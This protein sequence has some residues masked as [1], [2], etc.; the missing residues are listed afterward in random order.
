MS[1]EN[2]PP[3]RTRLWALFARDAHQAVVLRRGPRRHFRL[4]TW[5]THTDRF[6]HGQWMTGD[7]T[8]Y[9]LSPD[10]TKLIYWA[11]QYG[12]AAVR[13]RQRAEAEARPAGETYDPVS[14]RSR[15]RSTAKRAYRKMPRYLRD[16]PAWPQPPASRGRPN[17]GVWT[18]ISTP[19]YFSALAIWPSFGHWT[20]GGWFAGSHEL[21]LLEGDCGM[22][23]KQNAPLPRRLKIRPATL[24]ERRQMARYGAAARP[25]YDGDE[26]GKPLASRLQAEGARWVDWT[27]PAPTGDLLFACDGRIWRLRNWQ[28]PEQTDLI[29]TATMIADFRDMTFASLPPPASAMSWGR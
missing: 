23:A 17:T 20:G 24:T 4:S 26:A 5:D 27:Y 1:P 19:P 29:A 11:Y 10:G 7:V 28:G 6:T 9:D 16:D 8:L 25:L 15:R 18:A 22:T 13:R 12:M 2:D 3:Y 14:T 21:V